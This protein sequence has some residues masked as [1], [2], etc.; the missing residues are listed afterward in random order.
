MFDDVVKRLGVPL[1]FQPYGMTEVNALALFH[2]LDEPLELRAQ[3]G[4][5][6]PP[7][8][9]VRGSRIRTPGAV[10][11]RTRRASCSSAGRW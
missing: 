11:R 7:G 8:L 5:V 6:P 9:E 4:I 2:D 1:A 3:P 10:R